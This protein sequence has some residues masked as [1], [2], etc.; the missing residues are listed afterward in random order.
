MEFFKQLKLSLKRYVVDAILAPLFG[1]CGR[2]LRRH[3]QRVNSGSS[4]AQSGRRY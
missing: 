2:V 1:G 3:Y 4:V